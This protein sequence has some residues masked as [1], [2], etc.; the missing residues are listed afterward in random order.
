MLGLIDSGASN[1]VLDPEIIRTL[2]LDP[3]GS[4]A[5]HTS[6]SGPGYVTRTTY[7]CLFT[8]GETTADPLSKTLQI[9]GCELASQ[10]FYALIGRDF[11][12]ACRFVY[13]GPR[14]TFTLEYDPPL[15]PTTYVA[16]PG[17]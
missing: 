9:I 8:V 3:R 4:A 2:G 16:T 15:R 17:A 5:I 1:S 7:D 11:L 6:S 12:E 14:K 13:D 10:G